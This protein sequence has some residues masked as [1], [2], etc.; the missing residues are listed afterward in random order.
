MRRLTRHSDDGGVRNPPSPP[1]CPPGWRIGPPDFVGVGVQRCGT[2]RW[3][4]LIGSHP[5]V[6]WPPAAK[7]LHYFDRYHLGGCGARE[8]AGYH[9]F[10]P[11][12]GERKVG[13]WTPLYM[14]APWVPALLAQAAPQARLLVLLRDPV[15]RYISGLQHDSGHAREQGVSLSRLTPLDAF[16]RGLYHAQLIRLLSHFDRSQILVLQYERCVSEPLAELRKTFQFLG[17]RDVEFV[18]DLTITP[19]RQPSKP[20]LDAAARD[21]YVAAY[22]DDVLALAQAF[23]EIDLALWPNFAPL[24]G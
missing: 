13:E 10:F 3:I 24:A 20:Q 7:E 16:A 19:N 4:R 18:P 11:R 21:A 15:E 5:E 8:I 12:D 22:R 2:T 6:V 14:S 17:L 23:P 1:P 9:E